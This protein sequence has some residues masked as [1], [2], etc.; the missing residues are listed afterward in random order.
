MQ[1]FQIAIPGYNYYPGQ[2][3]TGDRG[4]AA[5]VI[6]GTNN[7][8]SQPIALQDAL[9][10]TTYNGVFVFSAITPTITESNVSDFITAVLSAAGNK[11]AM[12]WLD[13][14]ANIQASNSSV[15]PLAVD[16]SSISST[17]ILNMATGL[18]LEMQT[19]MT[20]TLDNTTIT[21]AGDIGALSLS[22]TQSLLTTTGYS[23]ATLSFA[24]SAM[25]S[26]QF[27]AYIAI[28]SLHDYLQ[29]GFQYLYPTGNG[30]ESQW[31]PIAQDAP[32]GDSIQ[33]NI[34]IDPSDVFNQAF[35]PSGNPGTY[36]IADAYN[37]R[38]TYFNLSGK[39]L[40]SGAATSLTSNYISTF[41]APVTLVPVVQAGANVLPA[42]FVLALSVVNI[43]NTTN[44]IFSPEGDFTIQIPNVTNALNTN[45]LCGLSATE[46]FTV[47]PQTDVVRY[48]SGQPAYAPLF[49]F[50]NSSMANT[51][52]VNTLLT[53]TYATSWAIPVSGSTTLNKYI[54][55]PHGASL[56][57]ASQ[58]VF[59]T[60]KENPVLG[61]Y[62]G[63][64]TLSSTNTSY[65]V[66]FVP[67]VET[68]TADVS[69]C[70]LFEQQIL[71]PVRKAYLYENLQ[72]QSNV[73]PAT[74]SI[75]Q[76]TSPQGLY[77]NV[78]ENTNQWTLLQLA[79]NT[80]KEMVNGVWQS[81]TYTLAFQNL[82]GTLQS[83]FQT[84]Q[85]FLVMS[86]IDTP[87]QACF[88]ENQ[89]SIE[90][91][92]F[93]FNIPT[94]NPNGIFKNVLIFKFIKNKS[95]LDTVATPQQ[96]AMTDSF[97]YTQDSSGLNNLVSWMT[98]YIQSGCDRY[99]VNG[100]T[101]YEKFYSVA[102]EPDWQG[103]IGLAVDISLGSFPEQLQGLL[104]GIDLTRFNAHHFG[105]D[106]NNVQLDTSN[107]NSL[108]MQNNSSLFGLIDYE[109]VV[110][111][112]LNYNI[113]TYQQQAPINTTSDY[114]F[115]VLSLKVLFENSKITNFGSYLA[116]T[117]NKLFGEQVKPDNRQNLLIFQGNYEDHDNNPV[118][119][120]TSIPPATNQYG[121]V[122]D[123]M[124]YM[125]SKVIYDVEVSS[126]TFNTLVS[127]S[128]QDSTVNS[129]FALNGF[130]NFN[131]LPGFDIFSYGSESQ[132]PTPTPGAG[133][134][135]SNLNVDFSFPLATPLAVTF[136][137]DIT[138]M[139]FDTSQSYTRAN[140][141][142]G[143]FPIQLTG[144]IS[145]DTSGT[146]SSL[147]YLNVS[148]PSL[149][150]KV[151]VGS[152]WYGLQYNLNMGTLGALTGA[153]GFNTTFLAL[154]NVGGTGAAAALKLP[155]V[156][157]Q[158]PFF[159][160]QGVL[161]V[162]IGNIQLVLADG[163]TSSYL[164]KINNIALKFLSV[165]FPP[166]GNVNFF[167]F[168]NPNGEA[169]PQS[170]GWYTGYKANS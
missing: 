51:S 63:Q 96:W 5:F 7:T 86:C 117:I 91:W 130:I 49:P 100:D 123:Y 104:A 46:Y 34:T 149:Q 60:T 75:M 137:F 45:L 94:Q 80:V 3:Q 164:M 139:S 55:Q 107:N 61:F 67:Y 133:L 89:M 56:Y 103:I 81:D 169:D 98:S 2:N 153:L 78:D 39:N 131:S 21:F 48:L 135:F 159:S 25:G 122:S 166:G 20:I 141:L 119:T 35:A 23:S 162:N 113:T 26:L 157:P 95:L 114:V 151:S 101:D 145:N 8:V 125:N 83:A 44:F 112:S 88:A 93:V 140:S 70:Q 42:R 85:L 30:D 52:N 79:A 111:E 118:Y 163:T 97:N 27:S 134:S 82:T 54:S 15:I 16:G 160:L 154:W 12:V 43:T 115:K 13:D 92:P 156:N 108:A 59:V 32:F 31:L 161:K 127:Q 68:L 71:G 64:A 77:I 9:T 57:A 138:Q 126:A 120:F 40:N 69:D 128:S 36:T 19:G 106:V 158:A 152:K 65:T 132:T 41:G 147:G 66:P 105:I 37:S 11:R 136:D 18:S 24:G 142:V 6:P 144:I 14:P 84:N 102:T 124:L 129:V 155:G 53:N 62:P 58:D 99:S 50:S 150:Q 170:V 146:P 10:N 38:R 148:L 28:Q 87:T 1:N 73:Q 143:N 29:W 76:T 47:T 116:L 110:F 74:D 17:A 168:G 4:F 22:G 33:F 165:S 121:G 167:L 90:G 72:P 109:D